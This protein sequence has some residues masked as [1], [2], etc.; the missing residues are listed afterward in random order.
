MSGGASA[1]TVA[2]L[3]AAALSAGSAIMQ[4]QNAKETGRANQKMLDQQAEN[5]RDAAIA[6]AEKIRIAAKRHAGSAE[7]AY[8]AS[9][10]DV[11]SGSAVRVNEQIYRD[12]ESDA[13]MTIL[14]G[15]RR[16]TSASNEGNIVRAQGDKAMVAGVMSASG[17]LLSGYGKAT[18]WG[19]TNTGKK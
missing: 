18:A 13:Y 14:T 7:A 3:A 15:N 2:M 16:A 12:S 9:G 6:Q 17:S 4:A 1:V 19:A 8:A 10:I 5:E 11:G